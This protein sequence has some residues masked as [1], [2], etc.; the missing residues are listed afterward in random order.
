MGV[1]SS[2]KDPKLT[3]CGPVKCFPSLTLIAATARENPTRVNDVVRPIWI[4]WWHLTHCANV[5]L[6]KRAKRAAIFGIMR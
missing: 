1:K 3:S 6:P 2:G 4:H 5:P